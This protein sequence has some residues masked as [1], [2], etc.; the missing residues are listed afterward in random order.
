MADTTPSPAS[1][2]RETFDAVAELYDRA[3]PGYPAALFDDLIALAGLPDDAR[4]LEIGCGTGQATLPLAHRGFTIDA[5]ELGAGLARV[6][7]RTLAPFPRVTVY[8]ADFEAW[9]PPDEPYDLVLAATSWHWLDVEAREAKAARVLR[10]GG[11]VA[12]VQTEHIAGG[13][14]DFFHAVQAPCYAVFM[15]D[16][17][18]LRLTASSDFPV[19]DGGL[20][21]S[22]HFEAPAT[23]SYEWE[24]SYT[25]ATYIDVLNTYSGH[26][27]LPP[28]RR[29]ALLECIRRT[30]DEQFGGE[31]RKRYRNDLVV[32]QKA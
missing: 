15:G 28:D 1:P 13:T 16:D 24:Q 31:I 7:R 27:D 4:L 6:A 29:A 2:L 21:T 17:P 14:T 26:I 30:I 22:P 25:S 18:G 5:V 23:R 20:S 10:A 11:S 32:A 3:R 12:L 8:H 9:T 19:N